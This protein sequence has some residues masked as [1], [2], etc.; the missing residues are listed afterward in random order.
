MPIVQESPII[1]ELKNIWAEEGREEG[2]E[3]ILSILRSLITFRFN[4][5]EDHFD[6]LLGQLD[7]VA[8]AQLKNVLFDAKSLAALEQALQQL[9]QAQQDKG[10]VAKR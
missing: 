7:L 10:A 9:A 3:A 4:V 8:L 2:R 6:D 1:Q 5:A